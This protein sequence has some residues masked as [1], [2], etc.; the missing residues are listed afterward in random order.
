MPLSNVVVGV[1][2]LDPAWC[3]SAYGLL[4]TLVSLDKDLDAKL[5]S[6]NKDGYFDDMPFYQNYMHQLVP[7]L[8]L[9]G[10]GYG[11][12]YVFSS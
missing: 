9:Y 2:G 12:Y 5:F 7:A 6:E 1:F 3:V 11:I 4:Y 10:I 8:V